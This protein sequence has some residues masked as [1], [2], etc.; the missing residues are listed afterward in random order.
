MVD[1]VL[2]QNPILLWLQR[3]GLYQAS[4]FSLGAF[5]GKRMR[6]RIDYYRTGKDLETKEGEDLLD[7]FLKAK[8]THPDIMSE[9]EV[10]STSMTM[11]G[12]GADTMLD[13]LPLTSMQTSV[14]IIATVKSANLSAAYSAV[15]LTAFFYFILKNPVYYDKLQH[16]LDTQLPARDLSSLKGDVQFTQAQKLPYLRACIQETFRMHPASALQLERVLPPA[17]ANIAGEQIPGGTVVSISTWAT[18]RNPEVFGEDAKIFRPERW[19]EASEER[20]RLMDKTMLHFGAGNHLC[21]GKS[22]A[23]MEIYKVIPSLLRTFKVSTHITLGVGCACSGSANCDE[24]IVGVD[25]S[26]EGLDFGYYA[27]RASEGCQ[28]AH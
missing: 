11:I 22:I 5:V 4:T 23:V 24:R 3:Q 27:F 16:E 17:G 19:L 14:P 20:A 9:R 8:E 18:H 25:E 10:V 21:L 6:D 28:G 12:A 1:K 7:K 13:S 2:R 15:T 26:G